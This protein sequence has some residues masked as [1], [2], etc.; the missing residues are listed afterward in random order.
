MAQ[1]FYESTKYYYY[2]G[3]T[4]KCT[5]RLPKTGAKK[6]FIKKIYRHCASVCGEPL[7]FRDYSHTESRLHRHFKTITL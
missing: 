4:K 6:L 1:R 2:F 5:L 7:L 3:N